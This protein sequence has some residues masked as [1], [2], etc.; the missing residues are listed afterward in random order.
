VDN[1]VARV[2]AIGNIISQ[3]E[4]ALQ[5]KY[6]QNL[7]SKFLEQQQVWCDSLG[8]VYS[9]SSGSRAASTGNQLAIVTANHQNCPLLSQGGSKPIYGLIPHPRIVLFTPIVISCLF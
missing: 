6:V 5:I 2:A 7:L 8:Q 4:H 1:T 3:V 9:R